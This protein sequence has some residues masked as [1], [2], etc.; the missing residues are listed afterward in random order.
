[1]TSDPTQNLAQSADAFDD[2]SSDDLAF[3]EDNKIWPIRE[4][5][6]IQPQGVVIVL[7]ATSRVI[8]QVSANTKAYLGVAPKLLLG[9]SVSK[10]FD[11]EILPSKPVVKPS[12]LKV[13]SQSTSMI[14]CDLTARTN[15]A[16]F[17]ARLHFQATRILIELEPKRNDAL[18]RVTLDRSLD[19]S[20]NAAIEAISTTDDL[21]EYARMVAHE[22]RSLSGFDRVMVY[23]FE[24]DCS[25]VVIVDDTDAP[26]ES[27]LG[28]H[29]PAT[30]IPRPARELFLETGL[31]CIPDINY[32]RVR[33]VTHLPQDTTP[34]IDV[35]SLWLRGVSPPHVEYL[36]NMG[37]RA[38]MTIALATD[39]GLWGLVACH[40]Y[41]VKPIDHPT[42]Q[43]L[44]LISKIANL[45]LLRQQ[46]LLLQHYQQQNL[47]LLTKIREAYTANSN[48]ALRILKRYAHELI[49]MFQADGVVLCLDRDYKAI[50]VTPTQAEIQ[51]FLTWRLQKHQSA[52]IFETSHLRMWYPPSEH[53]S[54]PIAGLLGV[55]VVLRNVKAISHHIL[56][57]R[58]EQAHTI[59]W[60][61]H[62][63]SS[64]IQDETGKLRLGPRNS[65]EQ[66]KQNVRHRS[67]PWSQSECTSARDLHQTLMLAALNFSTSALVEAA[68]QA[69][70]ANLSKSNFLAN[71]SH[72]IRT[73]MNAVLG[74]TE[75]LQ[76]L[77][78]DKLTQSYLSA[79][80]SSGR[81]LLA[82]INDILDLSKIEAGRLELNPEPVNLRLLVRDI[83]HIFSQKA[84]SKHL[85][86]RVEIDEDLPLLLYFDEVRLRQILFNVVGNALKFTDRG[87]VSIRLDLCDSPTPADHCI[88]L[89]IQVRDTGI[90]IA[91]DEQ[92][93][94]FESFTQ[95]QPNLT[96]RFGGTGLGLSITRRL[97]D[98][99]NST[100]ELESEPNLGSTFT[101]TFPNVKIAASSIHRS[102]HDTQNGYGLEPKHYDFEQFQAAH[103]LI[104]DDI[105]SN[106]DLLAGYL[107]TTTHTLSFAQDGQEAIRRAQVDLPDVVLMDLRMPNMDGYEATKRLKS[108]PRTQAIPVIF[109]TASVRQDDEQDLQSLGEGLVRKPVSQERLFH[110]LR[111]V[112]PF[113]S[114]E[115]S[116]LSDSNT[117]NDSHRDRPEL[118]VDPV[119]TPPDTTPTA[120]SDSVPGSFISDSDKGYLIQQFEQLSREIWSPLLHVL[121]IDGLEHFASVLTQL[122][123]AVPYPPLMNYSQI[124]NQQLEDF[125]WENLPQTIADFVALRDSLGSV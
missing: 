104:V 76:P 12:Q 58:C 64:I 86:L 120:P 101:F 7:N 25:G 92:E 51:Q 109:V 15:Q 52:D 33:F 62:L 84:Q 100:I 40:H 5:D 13:A 87:E 60:A 34:P 93:R 11:P 123:D 91:P 49:H 85:E 19:R 125:D 1:M 78:T 37:V 83:Q 27:F 112:L 80:E 24:P 110:A 10:L 61:G 65:F 54:T 99:M 57:F 35:S 70:A 55:S 94:I 89:R 53:W 122:A 22:V 66:W 81:T 46:N 6:D 90:G 118:P 95:S 48:S 77:M 67:L 2:L 97:I 113:K 106:R 47:A 119:A 111:A 72:E 45:S 21:L 32:S 75:L 3:L 69:E 82:L 74:F 14:E 4:I 102:L 96:R 114:N 71:M 98:M 59:T 103:I 43:T 18:T 28:L 29:F 50:G 23:R 16:E 41:S 105:Q 108:L 44:R 56:L 115:S 73:P 88:N 107:R 38:S 79:I 39:T 31:R 26:I 8:E 68:R 20:L 42:R 117:S 36:Q 9:R 30:D 17:Y 63:S 116:K 124:L 121:D